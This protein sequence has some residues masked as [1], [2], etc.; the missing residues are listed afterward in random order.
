MGPCPG[1]G[2]R[3]PPFPALR[4]RPPAGGTPFGSLPKVWVGGVASSSLSILCSQASSRTSPTL[5][6]LSVPNFHDI[7]PRR[8]L[9]RH[10]LRRFIRRSL[11]ATC[12]SHGSPPHLVSQTYFPHLPPWRAPRQTLARRLA[13]PLPSR[14]FLPAAPTATHGAAGSGSTRSMAPRTRTTCAP[15][16][17]PFGRLASC[18][19]FGGTSNMWASS[20]APFGGLAGTPASGSSSTFWCALIA[21]PRASPPQGPSLCLRASSDL[22]HVRHLVGLRIIRPQSSSPHDSSVPIVRLISFNA[23]NADLT[24][25]LTDLATDLDR[26]HVTASISFRSAVWSGLLG[27]AALGA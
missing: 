19:P 12:P 20:F 2:F 22:L 16:C 26:D 7:P 25:D 11:R 4:S 27:E 6:C 9:L 13:S 18:A 15:S 17:A 8:K 5:F 10:P 21:H 23:P 14:R 1:V 3:P 24:D